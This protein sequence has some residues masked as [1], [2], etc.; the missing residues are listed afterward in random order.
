MK[1]NADDNSDPC[2]TDEEVAPISEFTRFI[3]DEDYIYLFIAIFF[4]ALSG[5]SQPAQL[6]IFGNVLDAFNSGGD[7]TSQI[8]LLAG[9]YCVVGTI[10]FITSSIQTRAVTVFAGNVMKRARKQYF[11]SLI[12]KPVSF[13]GQEILQH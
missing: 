5:C 11:E 13:F 9:L 3:G 12:R 8:N 7:V 2:E 10:T 1:G 4:A 6:V